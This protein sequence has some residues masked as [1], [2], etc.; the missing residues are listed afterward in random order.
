MCFVSAPPAADNGIDALAAVDAL[1]DGLPDLPMPD[2]PEFNQT[3]AAGGSS[4]AS[5]VEGSSAGGGAFDDAGE[6]GDPEAWGLGEGSRRVEANLPAPALWHLWR[7]PA[8]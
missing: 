7:C 1:W 6:G 2:L 4:A 5:A 8:G 3:S